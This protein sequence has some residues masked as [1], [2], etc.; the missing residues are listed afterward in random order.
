MGLS[1]FFFSFLVPPAHGLGAGIMRNSPGQGAVSKEKT[2]RADLL[3]SL[4]R[5]RVRVGRAEDIPVHH[6]Q[7]Q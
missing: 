6:A 5:L 2:P 1:G 4:T 3:P 7:G